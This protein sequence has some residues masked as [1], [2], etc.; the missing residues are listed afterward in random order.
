MILV[1]GIAG[2]QDCNG[3]LNFHPRRIPGTKTSVRFPLLYRDRLFRVEIKNQKAKY[4]LLE[5]DDLTLYHYDEEVTLTK[6][7]PVAARP[8]K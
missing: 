2:M 1:Y 3:V 5:G 8:V 4:S 6:K 7:N